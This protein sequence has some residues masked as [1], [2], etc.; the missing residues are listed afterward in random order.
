MGRKIKLDERIFDAD[1]LSPEGKAR[2]AA[3][4]FAN[5]QI[6]E[7]S[8]LVAA[9]ERAHRGYTEDLKREIIKGRSGVDISA[10]FAD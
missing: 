9:L 3:L 1:A 6:A 4:E 10:L 5:A 8:R 2:L 7:L